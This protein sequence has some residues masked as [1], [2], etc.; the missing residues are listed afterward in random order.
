MA[1]ALRMQA[2]VDGSD[3]M[4]SLRNPSL[5]VKVIMIIW[6]ND[7]LTGST[8]ARLNRRIL[9]SSRAIRSSRSD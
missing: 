6:H 3:M 9:L 4:G 5:C 8:E 2:V 1:M 7:F